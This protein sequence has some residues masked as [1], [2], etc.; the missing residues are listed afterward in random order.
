MSLMEYIYQ[1]RSTVLDVLIEIHLG[2]EVSDF[3]VGRQT[4]DSNLL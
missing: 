4:M 1:Y 2:R 3:H